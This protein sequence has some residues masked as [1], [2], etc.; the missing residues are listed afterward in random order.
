MKTL[1]SQRCL[2]LAQKMQRLLKRIAFEDVRLISEQL[3]RCS[4]N[5]RTVRF[6]F[7]SLHLGSSLFPGVSAGSERSIARANARAQFGFSL[8]Q[9]TARRL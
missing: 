6:R 9:P 8:G 7:F 4:A 1:A 5:L 2:Q 3:H